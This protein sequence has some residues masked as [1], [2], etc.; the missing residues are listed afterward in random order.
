MPPAVPI[1]RPEE[2]KMYIHSYQIHNVLNVY[3]K[4]LSQPAGT[5]KTQMPSPEVHEDRIS[6]T[7][8]G[9]RQSIFDKISTEIVDRITRFDSTAQFE[10]TLDEKLL[11]D[12]AS[13]QDTDKL[14]ETAFSYSV[15][16]KHN[17]KVTNTLPIQRLA[18]LAQLPDAVNE[19]ASAA[20]QKT[21]KELS[22]RSTST[23][24]EVEV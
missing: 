21:E 14:E 9:Q 4:Q 23:K 7:A 1:S 11:P 8:G 6:L 12:T 3:R 18:P 24:I 22:A 15:I 16:D 20:S 17:R 5:G 13:K 19:T 2:L 10:S